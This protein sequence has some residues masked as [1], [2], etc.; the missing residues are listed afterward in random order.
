MASNILIIVEGYKTESKFFNKFLD[1]FD[2]NFDIYCFGANIYTLYKDL[3]AIDFNGDL[4]DILAETYP[5]KKSILSKKYAYTYLIFD[6]DAH[7]PKKNDNRNIDAIV[8]DNIQKLIEMANYFT[9][10][11][12]PSKGKLYINYPM[13][14]SYRDCDHFFEDKYSETT[15]A[16]NEL[17]LYKS[18][19]AHRDICRIHINEYTKENFTLLI[20]QNIYKLNKIYS[21]NWNK[22]NYEEYM[23]YS[24]TC[25]ILSKQHDMIKTTG[26]I[27]V[28]N[29]SLFLITDYYGNEENFYDS[30]KLI[31]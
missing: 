5:S 11:T 8:A 13:M 18:R 2:L 10:E 24:D 20:L 16:I 25:K 28:I 4:K 14:E 9:D 19:V 1:V 26:L 30:L 29:T 3:K 17:S 15:V 21:N 22:L 27:S 31:V 23:Q 7:H 6:C 12:D